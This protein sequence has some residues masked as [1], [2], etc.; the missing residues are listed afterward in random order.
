MDVQ[1]A[2]LGVLRRGGCICLILLS[3]NAYDL[4]DEVIPSPT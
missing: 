4:S 3:E 2:L 1:E